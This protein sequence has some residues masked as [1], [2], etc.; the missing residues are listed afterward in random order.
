[1]FAFSLGIVSHVYFSEGKISGKF[2]FILERLFGNRE[3]DV[4]I[5]KETKAIAR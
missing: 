4:D 5:K 1:M 3:I 2:E